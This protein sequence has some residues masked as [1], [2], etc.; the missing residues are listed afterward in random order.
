[1][2]VETYLNPKTRELVYFANKGGLWNRVSLRLSVHSPS[3][4]HYT[5]AQAT[6]QNLGTVLGTITGLEPCSE[7][8]EYALKDYLKGQRLARS[9]HHKSRAQRISQSQEVTL[10]WIDGARRASRENLKP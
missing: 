10:D 7:C 5:P 3:K 9:T 6:S 8:I 4:G 1:M 2:P